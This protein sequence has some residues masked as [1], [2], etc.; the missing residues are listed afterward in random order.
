MQPRRATLCSRLGS[1]CPLLFSQVGSV[2]FLFGRTSMW[3]GGSD[4]ARRMPLETGT[5]GS[6]DA[7]RCSLARV[8]GKQPGRISYRGA[9]AQ[10]IVQ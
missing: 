3:R 5:D 6:F 2:E 4:G 7:A 8:K 10:Y 9:E 1:H